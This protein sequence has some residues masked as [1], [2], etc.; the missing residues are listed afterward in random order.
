ML[1]ASHLLPPHAMAL[2]QREAEKRQLEITQDLST[3]PDRF[4][5]LTRSI[6]GSSRRMR[7]VRALIAKFAADTA[8]VLITGESG[9]GKQLSARAIH[10][11]SSR[12]EHAFVPVNCAAVPEELLDRELFGHVRGA[13]AGAVNAR[14]GRFQIANGGTLFLDEIGEMSVKLQVKLLR[15][16]QERQFEPVG[17]DHAVHVDVRVIAAAIQ[18]LGAAVR[19]GK[20]R[21]D[22]FYRLNILPLELPPL[23]ARDGDIPLLTHYFLQLH[24]RRKAKGMLQIEA[25]AMTAL[26]RYSWPGNVR[27]L[28]NLVERWVVLNDDA[29][30]RSGGLPDYIVKNSIP[31]HHRSNEALPTEGVDL[32]G[33]LENIENGFI[34]QALQRAGGNKTRAAELLSLNR[35]TFVERLR[36]KGMLQSARADGRRSESV[37]KMTDLNF[38]GR[39]G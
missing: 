27:E 22:L 18:D 2:S 15:V 13:F 1:L 20:F 14:Q 39:M 5:E 10:E 38:L 6:I 12:R 28:E 4:D 26:E 25:S 30:I 37:E 17:S 21:E 3:V 19:Q 23:R 24:T 8:T 16:L 35:T 34:E 32:D 29:I 7:S 31:Q 11:L 33:I 9:T 36:K